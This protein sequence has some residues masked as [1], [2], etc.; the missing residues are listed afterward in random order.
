MHSYYY[1]ALALAAIK[2][3]TLGTKEATPYPGGFAFSLLCPTAEA[4]EF[5]EECQWHAIQQY[6]VVPQISLQSFGKVLHAHVLLGLYKVRLISCPL[7]L[8]ENRRN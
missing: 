8:I 7:I 4:A 3:N 5:I 1:T 2:K 6:I